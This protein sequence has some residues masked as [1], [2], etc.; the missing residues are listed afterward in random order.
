MDR[1]SAEG[2]FQRHRD[3]D[4]TAAI[5]DLLDRCVTCFDRYLNVPESVEIKAEWKALREKL[6][7]EQRA[8]NHPELLR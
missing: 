2:V 3:A 1:Q 7:S 4:L 8:G 5:A 6:L